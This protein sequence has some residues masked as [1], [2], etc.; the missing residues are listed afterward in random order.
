[1]TP[2]K[3]P[4]GFSMPGPQFGA[5]DNPNWL[6]RHFQK[7]AATLIIVLLAVGGFYFY[8]SYQQRVKTLAPALENIAASPT[9]TISAKPS[10]TP[11]ETLQAK[12]PAGCP[13]KTQNQG[14]EI[15]V[16]IAKGQGRTH[17]A[18]AALKEYLKDKP[19][20]K[21][22]LTPEHLI[23]LE[24]WLQK[25]VEPK[26]TLHPGD[27]ISF[28][29]ETFAHALEAALQLTDGQLKNLSQYVPLVPSLQTT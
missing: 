26:T 1:M 5:P 12:C 21:A 28:S 11:Q 18:R 23:Y 3:L 9:A 15:V 22:Q 16:T 13:A 24:D 6:K 25:Q 17:A 8:Q 10:P 19:E 20:L 14:N 4:P 29:D 2:D 27:Q 7:I